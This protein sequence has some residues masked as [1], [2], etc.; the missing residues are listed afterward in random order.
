MG[1]VYTLQRTDLLYPELSFRINGVLFE[2]ARQLG[3]GHRETYYQR[4]VAIGLKNEKLTFQE[5]VFVPLTFQGI[6]VG[7][8]FLDFLVEDS[9]VIELKRNLF[10]SRKIIDQTI[11][12]L[13]AMNLSLGIIAC[14]THRGVIIKRV[15]NH[16]PRH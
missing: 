14:F 7:K 3:G 10:V 15:I 1:G 2:V 4:A 12:Y 6:Q 5:Q 13:Q 11:Q 9:I 8:Y 16:T